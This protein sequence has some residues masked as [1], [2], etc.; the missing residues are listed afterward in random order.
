MQTKNTP[1]ILLLAD[2][3][4]F[5]GN[6]CG[7]IGTTTGE[8]AFNTGMSGYQ[9]I[10]TDP[11]YY[12]QI[13]TMANAHIG[14]YGAH[15]MEIESNRSQI[16]GFVVKKLNNCGVSQVDNINLNSFS[17]LDEYFSHRRAKKLGENDYGRCISV[18]KKTFLQ[19]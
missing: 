1:A 7:M 19:N 10:F 18:I 6:A 9:E 5:H 17:A 13:I 16:K 2:G 8:I 14:N 3:K 4:V 11:S 12:G 15:D